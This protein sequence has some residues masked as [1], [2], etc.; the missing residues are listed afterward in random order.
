M[1]GTTG[2]QSAVIP[3][4]S[5]RRIPEWTDFPLFSRSAASACGILWETSASA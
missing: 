5:I 3:V 1:P 2:M 4:A